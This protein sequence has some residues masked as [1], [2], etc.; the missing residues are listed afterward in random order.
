M[1]KLLLIGI[2]NAGP[3]LCEGFS[4]IALYLPEEVER[5]L[6]DLAAL[7]QAAARVLLLPAA[8]HEL[9]VGFV[10]LRAVVVSRRLQ[11][12]RGHVDLLHVQLLQRR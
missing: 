11:H 3:V 4:T 10:A 12:G 5:A 9:L 1:A 6:V 8:Q 7:G 2:I